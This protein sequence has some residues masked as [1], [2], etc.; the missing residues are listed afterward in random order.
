MGKRA[1]AFMDAYLDSRKEEIFKQ[2]H[3][4][5]YI[6]DVVSSSPTDM[7]YF[8]D[9]LGALRAGSGPP[10]SGTASAGSSVEN[11]MNGLSPVASGS[12]GG[13]IVHVLVR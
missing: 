12:S 7:V 5:I 8:L 11:T 10:S 13:P 9:I 4:L 6:F 1:P 3:T 2:V